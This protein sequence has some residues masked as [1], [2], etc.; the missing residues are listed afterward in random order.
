MTSAFLAVASERPLKT[1]EPC[2]DEIEAELAGL[3][4]LRDRPAGTIRITAGEHAA[5]PIRWPALAKLLPR[6]PDIKA[7]M[8]VI[9]WGRWYYQEIVED[10]VTPER[11]IGYGNLN[12]RSPVSA[13]V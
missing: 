2:F 13:V 1:I 9:V 4:E 3:S 12:A 10:L 8:T 5:E 6:Y 11:E 7:G